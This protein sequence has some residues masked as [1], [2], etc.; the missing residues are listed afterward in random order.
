MDMQQVN[1]T[2]TSPRLVSE[3]S[4]LQKGGMAGTTILTSLVLSACGGTVATSESLT[5]GFTEDGSTFTGTSENDT[6]SQAGSSANLTVNGF[7]G[8]D[9]I[10][11]GSGADLV[12]PGKGADTV[13][14]G[15]GNDTFVVVG[16][17]LAGEYSA[18]DIPSALD[19]VLTEATLNGQNVSESQVT[20]NNAVGDTLNGGDGTDTLHVYGTLDLSFSTLSNIE[21]LS[22]HSTVILSANQISSFVVINGD[23]AST[24]NVAV[25][26]TTGNDIVLNFSDLNLTNIN[27]VVL[28][29]NITL[30][31]ATLDALQS[32]GITILSGAGEL[33]IT[34]ITDSDNVSG[35]LLLDDQITVVNG[36]GSDITSDISVGQIATSADGNFLPEFI[37]RSTVYLDP[38]AS[39][40]SVT[41]L[42]NLSATDGA[43][44]VDGFFRDPDKQDMSFTLS[45]TDASKFS[46]QSASDGDSW[47]VLNVGQTVSA[48]SSLDVDV[49][50]TDS[51]GGFVSQNFDFWAV[52]EGTTTGTGGDDIL[53]GGATGETISGLG[54]ND[55]LNG[56]GGD[57]T[58][59]GGDGN[60]LLKGRF[61][62]DTLTGGAG[63]DTLYYQIQEVG[64][65]FLT[66][67]GSDTMRDFKIDTD[68]IQFEEYQVVGDETDTLAEFKAGFG[69]KWD[70]QA[71]VDLKHIQLVFGEL[72]ASGDPV[73]GGGETLTLDLVGDDVLSGSLETTV[74]SGYRDFLTVDLFIDAIGGNDAL[75]F[76]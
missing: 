30:K 3:R 41:L 73:V 14:T 18:S 47:L 65:K 74:D 45:G 25:N 46:I 4:K 63:A 15:A 36:S 68:I 19:G 24:L 48:G 54:G 67:D 21:N 22:I 7:A 28:A 61:G 29:D 2:M 43:S 13:N 50:S 10:T 56:G 53:L 70:A 44:E 76:V 20:E 72:D 51:S 40:S 42:A 69:T 5:V 26:D 58:L 32:S 62:D 11:T 31:V 34:A 37:G 55:H 16:T 12:R 33:E 35:A 71:S 17:T 9:V 23:G 66:A 60:D 39:S 75:D 49:T 59:N 6:L 1:S 64:G 8:W 57:D 38:I 52:A 27:Q